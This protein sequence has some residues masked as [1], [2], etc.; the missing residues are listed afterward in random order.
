MPQFLDLT[1]TFGKQTTPKEFHYTSFK[2]ESFLDPKVA[3]LHEIPRMGRSG[4]QI[5]LCYNL[6]SVERTTGPGIWSIRQTAVYHSFDIENGRSLWINIK[7]NENMEQRIT[8]SIRS[9]PQLQSEALKTKSGSFAATL[10]THLLVFEWSA[11]NWRALISHLDEQLNKLLIAAKAAPIDNVEAALDVD[12]NNL[13]DGLSS[14]DPFPTARKNLSRNTS[15]K[16]DEPQRRGTANSDW[17]IAGRIKTGFSFSRNVTGDGT[18]GEPR[19]PVS[20][21]ATFPPVIRSRTQPGS[22]QLQATG[23]AEERVPLS[24]LQDFK[25]RGLQ[26][27]TNIGSKLHEASLVMKLNTDIINE[28]VD[29]YEFLVSKGKIPDQFHQDSQAD[30][31]F[32]I[33]RAR[34]I[35]RDQ[36]M[37]R[38]RIETLMRM[39]ED[40]KFLVS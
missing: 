33:R 1:L 29:Y 28:I 38:S 27:L 26:D 39:L 35:I 5:R 37:E 11:E 19:S 18:L 20:A 9:S 17:S 16:N 40:G 10:I 3:E 12:W 31:E 15:A 4:R 34:G 8:D 36:Q 24:L 13:L 7:G 23:G 14:A 30:F 32:F 22:A 2:E 21:S 6:W 25:V